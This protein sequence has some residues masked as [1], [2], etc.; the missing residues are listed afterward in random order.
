MFFE[1]SFCCIQE[2]RDK[3]DSICYLHVL[4]NYQGLTATIST[5]NIQSYDIRIHYIFFY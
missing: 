5:G 3:K 1:T 4:S 2:E